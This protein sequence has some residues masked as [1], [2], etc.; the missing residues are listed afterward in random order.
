MNQLL[1]KF[2]IIKHYAKQILAPEL[3]Y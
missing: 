2:L 3:Q 1:I